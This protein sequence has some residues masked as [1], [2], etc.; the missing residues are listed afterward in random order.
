MN[1]LLFIISVKYFVTLFQNVFGHVLF[2][3]DWP[4]ISVIKTG[5]ML[6]ILLSDK[7][8]VL[9]PS[10]PYP[11]LQAPKQTQSSQISVV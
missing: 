1:I 8:K 7:A 5:N 3:Q 11:G 10:S 9:E 4:G 6:K 2:A